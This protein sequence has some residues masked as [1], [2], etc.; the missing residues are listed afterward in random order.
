MAEA[1]VSKLKQ[2]LEI[3]GIDTLHLSNKEADLYAQAIEQ[4]AASFQKL[5][6]QYSEKDPIL[7]LL[8]LLTKAQLDATAKL[9]SQREKTAAMNQVFKDTLGESHHLKFSADT[10]IELSLVTK[11]WLMVQGYLG[12]DFSLANDYAS[13]TATQIASALNHPNKEE[14][15]TEFLASFY[16]GK[17]KRKTS[18]SSI[19][20]SDKLLSLFNLS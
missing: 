2:Q 3:A 13:N 16:H 20:W 11:I 17:E 14:I 6:E 15:R 12:M 9:E 5:C 10:V 8:G 18:T 4:K 1:I 7:I 19:Q